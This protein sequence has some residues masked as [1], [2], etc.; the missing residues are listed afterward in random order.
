M[1]DSGNP[2][3]QHPGGGEIASPNAAENTPAQQPATEQQLQTAEQNIEQR[4]SAF[5]RSMLRLTWAAVAISVITGL[6]FAGQLYEMISGGTQTDKLVGYASRQARAGE[7]MAIAAGDQADAA[8]QFSDTAEDINGRMSD[9]VQQLQSAAT[10]TRTT[11]ANSEK[12]FRAEQRAWV[13]VRE[14]VS[15]EVSETTPWKVV[16]T[17]FNSGKSPARN[18][19]SSTR[20]KTSNTP[21]HGPSEDE[22]KRLVAFR[23]ANSIAPQ[24]EYHINIGGPVSGEPYTAEQLQGS[25]AIISEFKYIKDGTLILYYYGILRYDD[26]FGNHR[27][28]QWCIYLAN[29]TTKELGFCDAFNDLN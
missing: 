25:Q 19:Q 12:A 17:F 24:G 20:F 1:N 14:A 21:V 15:V 26:V 27:E 7:D 8:Q 9:A 23:P 29:P 18:V 5:E 10:N 3:Q 2:Q 4:M 6:I 11:I 16:V 22:I 28:T 13:G